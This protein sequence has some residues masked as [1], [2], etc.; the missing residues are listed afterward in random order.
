M[1]T[2]FF[3]NLNEDVLILKKYIHHQ[4]KFISDE[5]EKI[6]TEEE[7]K[8]QQL[9]QER[10]EKAKAVH[11]NKTITAETQHQIQVLEEKLKN[12]DYQ[13]WEYSLILTELNALKYGYCEF[14]IIEQSHNEFNMFSESSFFDGTFR[15]IQ[16]NATLV[17]LYIFWEDKLKRFCKMLGYEGGNSKVSDYKNYL[18]AH[19]IPKKIFKTGEWKFME[20]VRRLRNSVVHRSN[21]IEENVSQ[22]IQQM[23]GIHIDENF[24]LV[25]YSDAFLLKVVET[26]HLFFEKLR[27]CNKPKGVPEKPSTE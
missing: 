15:Y 7:P 13:K 18:I 22:K 10:I 25:I 16:N 19:Q 6:N 14:A 1:Y 5:V 23:E 26:I 12:K 11:Q 27:N 8:I 3:D 21:H 17:L 24:Y 20:T 9:I 4:N 2:E